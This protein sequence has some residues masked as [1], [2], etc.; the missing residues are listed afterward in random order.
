MKKRGMRNERKKIGRSISESWIEI[1][2]G[3]RFG[4]GRQHLQT[5]YCLFFFFFLLLDQDKRLAVSFVLCH[6][7]SYSYILITMGFRPN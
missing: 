6:P 4:E 3:F 5:A 2:E 1:G 7:S